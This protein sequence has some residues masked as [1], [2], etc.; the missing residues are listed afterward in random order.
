MNIRLAKNKYLNSFLVLL[1]V[2]AVIHFILL[3]SKTL[4]TGDLHVL[5]FFHIL[6]IDW[7]APGLS[8]G[9]G[10]DIISWITAGILYIAILK[11][12]K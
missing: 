2:S 10:G 11:L 7:F 6:D 3:V 1:L 4:A 5:N 8:A 12:N 9:F